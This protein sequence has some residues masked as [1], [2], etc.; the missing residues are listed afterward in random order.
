MWQNEQLEKILLSEIIW[1]QKEMLIKKKF[2]YKNHYKWFHKA[3]FLSS[4]WLG[5][6]HYY[7]SNDL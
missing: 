5:M 4:Q 1:T 2:G 3:L 6:I 7:S